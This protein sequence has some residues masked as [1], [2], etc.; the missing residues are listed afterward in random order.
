MGEQSIRRH[1]DAP[2]EHCATVLKSMNGG[3]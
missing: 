2:C 1:R 3:A